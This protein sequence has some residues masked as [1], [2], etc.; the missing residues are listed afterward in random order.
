MMEINASNWKNNLAGYI[1]I[2]PMIIGVTFMTVIPI[3][4]S[5]L[6]S[7]TEWNFLKGFSPGAIKFVGLDNYFRLAGD[8]TFKKSVMNNL[9]FLL[10]VPVCMAISLLLAIMINKYVYFKSFFKVIYFFPYISSVVAVSM[11]WML[12]FQPS[13]GPVNHVLRSIGISDPPLWLADIHF[14]L[15]SVMMIVVWI[16]IGFNLIIFMAG[17][18]AI[19]KDYYEAAELDGANAWGRFVHV[20]LPLTSPSSFFLLI[21]GIISSFKAFDMINVL[22]QGG[23]SSSTSIIVYELYK[24]AFVNLNMGY[25][26]SMAWLLFVL[27][28]AI[29]VGQWKMQ[30]KW[31]NY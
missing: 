9:I 17:L 28:F 13:L 5:L 29:T 2:G 25:A 16:N 21:T 8:P 23:P 7:F 22:T 31:V 15:P 27:L 19:S 3:V 6:L 11:I 30:K 4:I 14:A 12:L 10:Q 1:F 24:T 26:S 18:Q 20:T